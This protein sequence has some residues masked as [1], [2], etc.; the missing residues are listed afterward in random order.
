MEK[1]KADNN[2]DVVNIKASVKAGNIKFYIEEGCIICASCNN[3]DRVTVGKA[4]TKELPY[5][6]LSPLARLGIDELNR[7]E[8][9]EENE[10]AEHSDRR[11]GASLQ[12]D[13]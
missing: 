12:Q 4:I 10:V 7:R 5:E 9:S 6:Y 11:V 3:S 1:W 13:Q 8:E 2:V